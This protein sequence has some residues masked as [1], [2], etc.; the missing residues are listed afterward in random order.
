MDANEH[1]WERGGQISCLIRV[2]SREFAVQS[3]RILSAASG[4][5]AQR[6][7][8]PATGG[9]NIKLAP[10]CAGLPLQSGYAATMFRNA[11]L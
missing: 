10:R 9:V 3:L 11:R 5:F 7:S 8:G 4:S 1:E 2:N 6:E